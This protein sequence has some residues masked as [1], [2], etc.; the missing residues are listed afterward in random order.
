VT[1]KHHKFKA[2]G[3]YLKFISYLCNG[4]EGVACHTSSCCLCERAS[5][6]LLVEIEATRFCLVH[7]NPV[8]SIAIQDGVRR[9]TY[10]VGLSS[11]VSIAGSYRN[12]GA[13]TWDT[14]AHVSY[15]YQ[16]VLHKNKRI[17]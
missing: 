2:N 5:A 7:L 4:F 16:T 8:N 15:C 12:L 11:H 1:S 3:I 10:Y 17:S 13:E 14:Q 6:V 9:F